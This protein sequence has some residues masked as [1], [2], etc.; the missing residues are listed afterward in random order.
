M[1]ILLSIFGLIVLVVLVLWTLGRRLP[2]EHVASSSILVPASREEVWKTLADAGGYATWAADVTKVERLPDRDGREAFRQ[3]MGRNTFVVETTRSEPPSALVRTVADD[4]RVFSGDW[5]Y[6]LAP[7]EG[8]CRVTLTEHG[9]VRPAIPRFLVQRVF[10]PATYLKRHLK[11]LAARF[12][13]RT[14]PTETTRER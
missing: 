10:D 8:G 2:E 5:E 1:P 14:E 9:R 12:G 6:A 4:H 13:G 3:T 11:S 7:E